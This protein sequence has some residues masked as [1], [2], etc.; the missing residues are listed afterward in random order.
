MAFSLQENVGRAK[1][2]LSTLPPWHRAQFLP[3]E[4]VS[5]LHSA[6]E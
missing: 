3:R 1:S 4:F 6:E 2:V 5:Y